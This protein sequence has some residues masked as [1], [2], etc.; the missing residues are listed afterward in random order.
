LS[1]YGNLFDAALRGALGFTKIAPP[2]RGCP[3]CRHSVQAEENGPM[4]PKMLA[5][6][7]AVLVLTFKLSQCCDP[8]FLAAK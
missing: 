6:L 1:K 2:K 8:G 5:V 4:L 7:L 3:D